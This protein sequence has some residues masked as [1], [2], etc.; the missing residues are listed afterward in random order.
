MIVNQLN[1][2]GRTALISLPPSPHFS[3]GGMIMAQNF[4]LQ[5]VLATEERSGHFARGS[6]CALKGKRQA[7]ACPAQSV[8]RKPL[9]WSQSK[10]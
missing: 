2:I 10:Y 6:M 8:T 1:S 4:S 9:P 3:P 7:K 5:R